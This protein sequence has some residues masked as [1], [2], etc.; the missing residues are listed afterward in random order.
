MK[1]TLLE[2]ANL[3]LHSIIVPAE[4]L[5]SQSHFPIKHIHSYSDMG[6][7]SLERKTGLEKFEGQ[8]TKIFI[9]RF[10]AQANTSASLPL[11]HID[12]SNCLPLLNR[13]LLKFYLLSEGSHMG[14]F[15][16]AY[17][18]CTLLYKNNTDKVKDFFSIY[19]PLIQSPV[20]RHQ[21]DEH[22]SL[23]ARFCALT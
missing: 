21:F 23:Q 4:T 20:Q 2:T 14:Q 1:V 15:L 3:Y 6:R 12:L 5:A 10:L 11:Y 18:R 7:T 22:P 9:Q 8:P 16:L 13:M 19:P 17:P